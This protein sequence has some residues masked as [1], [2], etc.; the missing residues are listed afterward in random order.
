M[1]VRLGSAH[2]KQ[3][4]VKAWLLGFWRQPQPYLK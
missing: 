1:Q 3:K 4:A 2:K